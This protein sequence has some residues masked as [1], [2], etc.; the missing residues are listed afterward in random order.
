MRRRPRPTSEQILTPARLVRILWLG[1]VLAIGTLLV[2]AFAER[3]FPAR[4]DDPLFATTL[5]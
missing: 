5:A 3:M 1:V 4:A 2:L